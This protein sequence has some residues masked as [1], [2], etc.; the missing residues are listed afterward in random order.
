MRA[1]KAKHTAGPACEVADSNSRISNNVIAVF[2]FSTSIVLSKIECLTDVSGR[3]CCWCHIYGGP[4]VSRQNFLSHGKTF[5]LTAKHS[6]SRQ[7]TLSY[8]KTLFLTATFSFYN[9]ISQLHKW[10]G[11][12]S[13]Y[14]C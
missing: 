6:F 12:G 7:N 1:F 14:G 3:D 10:K 11:K 5:F 13:K 2:V 8:G 4:Q 9:Q